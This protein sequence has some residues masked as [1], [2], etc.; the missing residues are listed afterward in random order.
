M[1]SSD[2]VQWDEAARCTGGDPIELL[3]P[4]YTLTPME[5]MPG[6]L[7]FAP[8]PDSHPEAI[9]YRLQGEML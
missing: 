6:H 7:N 8:A 9:F 2:L 5:D 3:L 4:G 1:V